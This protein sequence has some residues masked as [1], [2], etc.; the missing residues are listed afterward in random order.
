MSCNRNTIQGNQIQNVFKDDYNPNSYRTQYDIALNNKFCCNKNIKESFQ[1]QCKDCK[2]PLRG[3]T[4]RTVSCPDCNKNDCSRQSR[5][6]QER[7][8]IKKPF[9]TLAF[10]DTDNPYSYNISYHSLS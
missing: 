2:Y 10:D 9:R 7:Q 6:P 4:K 3:P 5:I 8:I 1:H